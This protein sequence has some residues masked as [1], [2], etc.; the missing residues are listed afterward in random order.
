MSKKLF[1]VFLDYIYDTRFVVVRNYDVLGN[2][3]I[4]RE[5]AWKAIDVINQKVIAVRKLSETQ[6]LFEF[7]TVTAAGE[8]TKQSLTI[9]NI[10]VSEIH[11]YYQAWKT[12]TGIPLASGYIG[13]NYK[14]TL[15][16]F[17]P[18]KGVKRNLIIDF[19]MNERDVLWNFCKVINTL[20]IVLD[21]VGNIDHVVI[22][23]LIEHG[24]IF[25]LSY[26][27][28][29]NT[30][31]YNYSD[32]IDLKL[33]F[34]GCWFYK[35]RTDDAYWTE[36][37]IELSPYRI[38]S[39]WGKVLIEALKL[40]CHTSFGV[41]ILDGKILCSH[42]ETYISDGGRSGVHRGKVIDDLM[43]QKELMLRLALAIPKIY[44]KEEHGK[45]M[46]EIGYKRLCAPINYSS[47][48]ANDDLPF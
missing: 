16:V 1:E 32:L 18:S 33:S 19:Q 45:E 26:N 17:E 28:A 11:L 43:L 23:R 10:T 42:Y 36:V 12:P 9:G 14:T 13:C 27:P 41:K 22:E 48:N 8:F 39:Y 15:E 37:E 2:L 6:R 44:N 24:P 29:F 4:K 34:F 30:L 3:S 20:N 46:F 40:F 25:H 21:Q 7:G 38:N 5:E 47:S 35:Y 31:Q